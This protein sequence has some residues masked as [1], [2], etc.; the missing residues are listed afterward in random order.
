M[1]TYEVEY[2]QTVTYRFEIKAENEEA[3][4]EAAGDFW[5]NVPFGEEHKY[6]HDVEDSL[7]DRVTVKEDA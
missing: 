4:Q 5:R 6:L 7:V 3:A 2:F 1:K